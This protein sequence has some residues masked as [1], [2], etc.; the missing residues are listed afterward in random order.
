[1]N[2]NGSLWVNGTQASVNGN[3]SLWSSSSTQTSMNGSLSGTQ[4][5]SS[6]L[7][8][9][10]QT[11]TQ[12]GL[13]V[14]QEGLDLDTSTS[15]HELKVF[16]ITLTGLALFILTVTGVLYSISL[17]RR[18]R[19]SKQARIYESAVG[20][21]E[22]PSSTLPITGLS[23]AEEQSSSHSPS[24]SL[25]EE[26]DSSASSGPALGLGLG[27]G[28]G[29]LLRRSLRSSLRRHSPLLSSLLLRSSS[30][31][32]EAGASRD[33]SR[34]YYIY[35]NPLPVGKEDEEEEEEE[36]DRERGMEEEEERER[37]A[38]VVS[39][40]GGGGVD[41]RRG[42]V[43][44]VEEEWQRWMGVG[45]ET[46]ETAAVSHR[47]GPGGVEVWSVEVRREEEEE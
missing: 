17:V 10:N 39:Y 16:N 15:T 1:M 7:F 24:P 5:P 2:G 32:G 13:V 18:R 22:T 35:S 46:G 23:G 3:G 14:T 20:S 4:A 34:I 6:I 45:R 30:R 8:L 11:T 28:L 47:D 27:S 42:M 33:N 43:E 37:R 29:L 36:E 38:V 41:E 40:G 9:P 21:F 44:E 19:Q 31:R 12:G 26:G 25:V